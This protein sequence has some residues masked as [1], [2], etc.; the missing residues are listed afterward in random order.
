MSQRRL[1][2]GQILYHGT[3]S[4]AQFTSLKGP[5]WVSD[6]PA[7]ATWY[8]E[9]PRSG[10]PGRTRRILSFRL[11]AVPRLR[12]FQTA[13]EAL[14]YALVSVG[15]PPDIGLYRSDLPRAALVV[16]GAHDDDGWLIANRFKV[17]LGAG[18]DI[19]LCDPQKWL[20]YVGT[21]WLG[22]EKSKDNYKQQLAFI[23]ETRKLSKRGL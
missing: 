2:I 13:R 8:S 10:M 7:V 18:H 22:P 1:H 4:P 12:V 5:A 21:Q 16:C 9:T 3:D 15:L 14:R 20:S 6:E 17:Y 19:M 23:A 11:T